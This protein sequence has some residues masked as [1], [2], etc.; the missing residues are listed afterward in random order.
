MSIGAMAKELGLREMGDALEYSRQFQDQARRPGG[1]R[2]AA[3]KP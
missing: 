3:R 1:I 2:P